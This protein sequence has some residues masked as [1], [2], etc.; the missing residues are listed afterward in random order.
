MGRHGRAYAH[1]SL[2]TRRAAAR[3]AARGRLRRRRQSLAR[4]ALRRARR[5]PAGTRTHT[6]RRTMTVA[7]IREIRQEGA[8]SYVFSPYPEPV[9]TVNPGE[10]VAIHTADA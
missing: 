10:T 8:Y 5:P 9:A 1:G 6:T 4:R 3:V 7:D 2:R